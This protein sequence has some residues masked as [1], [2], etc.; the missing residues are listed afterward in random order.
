MRY[1]GRLLR[2]LNLK[3]RPGSAIQCRRMVVGVDE[4]ATLVFRSDRG[5]AQTRRATARLS[6][7]SAGRQAGGA[8]ESGRQDFVRS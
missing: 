4:L 1:G 2:G 5:T 7:F 8:C 6:A 3:R